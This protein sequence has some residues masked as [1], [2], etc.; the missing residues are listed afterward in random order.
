MLFRSVSILAGLDRLPE[1][2]AIRASIKAEL[3]TGPRL[4]MVDSDHGITNLHVPSDVIIDASMPAM[5]RNGGKLWDAAGNKADTLAVI[6]DSSYAGVYEAV[7]EDC[8]AHGALDPATMGSV[9]NVGLMAR[10]AEE[11]GSH[12]KT[13]L[14]PAPGTVEVVVTDG[15]GAS[16]GTVLL[17][18]DVWAGDIWRVYITQDEPV[19][20]WMRLTVARARTTETPA[21]F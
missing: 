15:A 17:S 2:G 8:R 3:A 7:I 12:D 9:P 5:I 10:R 6:P 21:V 16:P 14:I 13:F 1:G 20:D 18:H 19:R 4:S 11:Y